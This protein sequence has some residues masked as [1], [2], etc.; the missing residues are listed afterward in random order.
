MSLSKAQAEAALDHAEA[1]LSDA[2]GRAL[3]SLLRTIRRSVRARRPVSVTAAAGT[4]EPSY[5]AT[6]AEW[7]ALVDGEVMPVLAS[8][9]RAAYATAG[10]P[11]TPAVEEMIS[12]YL[13]RVRDRLVR[14]GNP[15]VYAESFDLIRD[16]IARAN[17]EGWSRTRLADRIAAELSW[18]A[19][20]TYWA[21]ELARTNSAIDAILD[22]LGP[23]GS[24]AREAARMND[25]RVRALQED[26]A[27]LVR[28]REA[29]RSHWQVRAERISR[30]ESTGAMADVQL[31]SL[32]A[33][34][35]EFKRWNST[36]DERTR[37]SHVEAD[38]QEVRLTA[39]FRVGDAMMEAPGDPTA[40]VEEV[41]NCVVGS[42]KV[43]W[44]GQV[45][46]LVTRREYSGVFIELITARG[47]HLTV[48][49]NHPILTP[50]GYLP[51]Q[52]L[53][54]GQQVICTDRPPSPE[55]ENGP[56]S[57]EE[58]YRSARDLGTTARVRT[59]RMDFHGDGSDSE[60]EIV[61]PHRHLRVESNPSPDS[62]PV[63]E[64]FVRLLSGTSDLSTPGGSVDSL[65]TLGRGGDD[66]RRFSP[67]LIAG[68]GKGS[69]FLRGEALHP[70][71]VGL[72]PSPDGQVHLAEAAS[73]DWSGDP[74]VLRHLQHTL[75]LG[76]TPS[77]VIQ[78]NVLAGNH[79]V[80]NLQTSEEWYI[81]NG[82]A[83]HNC[84]CFVT[85]V[86]PPHVD[87]PA[88][89]DGEDWDLL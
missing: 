21:D 34:G 87:P 49:P 70:E 4:P 3:R 88:G 32:A 56:S 80:Y 85:G 77:E 69:S 20:P 82:I 25:P 43:E 64:E 66:P 75:S 47:H 35:V 59:G 71:S 10:Y 27:R 72:G 44:P 74:E 76:M 46:D 73:D 1:A 2:T 60:V 68:A 24:P 23:P 54:E 48:T 8:E 30:T 83:Q 29:E 7:A 33:E 37:P 39:R 12:D 15:P 58:I 84:R 62:H 89:E 65:V 41:V 52:S 5:G 17:I 86:E 67:G 38:G 63:Q 55:V 9:M 26:R 51:A 16:T 78:V 11:L 22:P 13:S 19:T 14:G 50:E 28:L 57:I 81:G 18:D 6:A 61:R 79:A 36:Y 53:R 42:T 31:R 45:G 40:P